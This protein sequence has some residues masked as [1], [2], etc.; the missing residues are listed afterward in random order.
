[1]I[2]ACM[3]GWKAALAAAAASADTV[4]KSVRGAPSGSTATNGESKTAGAGSNPEWQTELSTFL[5]AVLSLDVSTAAS[6]VDPAMLNNLASSSTA[7]SWL[8]RGYQ[9]L[10][11]NVSRA[12]WF[13][14]LLLKNLMSNLAYILDSLVAGMLFVSGLFFFISSSTSQTYQPLTVVRFFLPLEEQRRRVY[15]EIDKTIGQCV[16]NEIPSYRESAR[17]H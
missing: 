2:S 11:S 14:T 9:I 13:I 5:K 12:S 15:L 17:G 7:A 3:P 8:E 1:M 10:Q 6:K 16:W 4:G